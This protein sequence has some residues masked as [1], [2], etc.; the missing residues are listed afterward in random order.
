MKYVITESRLIQVLEQFVD[1][2]TYD[3]VCY[4]FVDPEPDDYDNIWVFAIISEDWYFPD[5]FATTRQKVAMV[6]KIK[7]EVRETINTFMGLKNIRV[8]SFVRKCD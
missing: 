4:F 1:S 3:G 2:L 6:N 8:G 7:R 5:S